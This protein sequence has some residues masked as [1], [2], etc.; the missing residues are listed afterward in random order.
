MSE[1]GDMSG[2]EPPELLVEQ[3]ALGELLDQTRAAALRAELEREAAASGRDRLAELRVSDAEI[4][5]DYPPEQVAAEIRRRIDRAEADEPRRARAGLWLLAPALAATAVLIWV[6][7]RDH[8]ATTIAHT[9]ARVEEGTSGATPVEEGKRE[10][11]RIK[12]GVEPHLVVDR[13]LDA[14]HERLASGDQARPGDLLQVSYVPAGRDAGVILS[15]D[16]AGVVTLHHPSEPT[17]APALVEG[18][19]I[20]LAHAYELDEAPGFERFV[21]VT[22]DEGAVA[23]A[24]V[25]AAAEQLAAN[26]DS[27][28]SVPLALEGEGWMQHSIVLDKPAGEGEP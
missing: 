17:A 9:I 20:P 5:T 25:L 18:L 8:D 4:L 28:R 23:V 1:R 12:G 24:Q 16:G 6:V 13:K 22:R 3:L 7:T 11:T 26:P 19:E 15:I 2:R 10:P 27:A 14:G 21:F